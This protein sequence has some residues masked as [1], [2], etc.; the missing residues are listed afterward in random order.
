MMKYYTEEHEWVEVT[1]DEA[2]IGFS[3]YAAEQL[4][5]VSYVELP[6]DDDCFN[7]GDRLGSIESDKISADIYSPISG[8]ICAVNEMLADSPDLINESPEDKGWLCKMTDFD[9]AD[10]DDLM[11][12]DAYM[13]YIDTLD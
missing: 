1:D 4:G 13:D 12:E 6:E 5:E 8:T 9:P 2:T 10:L 11:D 3:S 7:I